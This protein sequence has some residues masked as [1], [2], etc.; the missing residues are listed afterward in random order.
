[1]SKTKTKLTWA[2]PVSAVLLSSTAYVAYLMPSGIYE[3]TGSHAAQLL[4]FVMIVAASIYLLAHHAV[5]TLNLP[6]RSLRGEVSFMLASA[7]VVSTVALHLARMTGVDHPT[8]DGLI[9]VSSIIGTVSL[10]FSIVFLEDATI[11]V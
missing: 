4:L 5:D 9:T 8:I 7:A 1:M 3:S 10:F 2:K 6:S 11:T